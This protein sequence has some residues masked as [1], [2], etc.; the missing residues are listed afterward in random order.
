MYSFEEAPC[1]SVFWNAGEEEEVVTRV[2]PMEAAIKE[3]VVESE[4]ESELEDDAN[5][6]LWR[7]IFKPLRFS[8]CLYSDMS[9]I[10]R[11]KTNSTKDAF[12]KEPKKVSALA[13][14]DTS[15]RGLMF[16]MSFIFWAECTE[17]TLYLQNKFWGK[18]QKV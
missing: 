17:C 10:C 7:A 13:G 5:V 6:P 9:F 15:G 8:E 2:L 11:R 14:L 12:F 4:D 1:A 18:G 16:L 3:V